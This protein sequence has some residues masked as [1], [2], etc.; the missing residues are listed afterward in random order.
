MPTIRQVAERAKVSISTVSAV[1]NQSAY[2]SPE[3]TLRVEQAA[4][5]LRYTANA[6]ARGLQSQ[7]TRLIGMLVP[8]IAEPVYSLMVQG[9]ERSLRQAGYSLLLGSTHNRQREQSRYLGMLRSKQVDGMLLL[10]GFGPEDEIAEAVE[11]QLPLVFVAREPKSVAG[12]VVMVDN[13]E[14]AR[15]GVAALIARGHRRIGLVV[16]PRDLAVSRSRIDG[17]RAALAQAGLG[18][19]ESLI[20]EGD[21]TDGSGRAALQK[22]LALREPPT[23]VFAT[24]FLM[25][26]GCLAECRALGLAVPSQLELMTWSD[27]PLLDVFDPPISSVEQPS[28]EMGERAAELILRRIANKDLPPQTIVLPT[29]VRLRG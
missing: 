3:L 1:L 2:V 27:S 9:V 20:C 12:D 19:D 5:E 8:D 29:H 21:Y 16:G 15:K 7:R 25:M 18:A 14:G 10:L 4:R 28:A 23:A 13:A 26:T 6:V 24:G 22:L 17:W 11:S